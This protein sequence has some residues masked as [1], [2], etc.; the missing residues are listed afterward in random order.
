VALEEHEAREL[1]FWR[2]EL[3]ER[4]GL[5]GLRALVLKLGE[6]EWLVPKLARYEDV[7]A[8]A[9]TVLELGAGEGWAA[10]AVK[11]AFPD[12]HVIA[13]DLSPDAIAAG[14]R[15]SEVF[16]AAPDRTL[17]C[18]GY[19]IPLAD[20]SVGL[21]F[22]FQ[23][24]HHFG[25]HERTLAEVHRVLRPGGTCLYLHEP[26]CPPSLHRLA[27]ARVN[28]K[29]P[30]VPEDVLVHSRLLELGRAVG[31]D[32]S[33]AFDP[34]PLN[35]RPGETLYYLALQ[36]LPFLWARLPCTADYRFSKPAADVPGRR[37]R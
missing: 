17:A 23:A 12:V 13:S 28:R 8:N 2:R 5:D 9:G 22:A 37:T 4:S 15:W 18:P 3:G 7:F 24:A 36:R 20:G 10:C 1:A 32:A 6:A 25:A 19:D 35:R 21:V 29:R 27:R 33:V 30:E 34:D 16:G 11:R 26:S 31:F 14:G